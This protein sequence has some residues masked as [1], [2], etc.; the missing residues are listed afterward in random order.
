MPRS[1]KANTALARWRAS[2]D[3]LDAELVSL[4]ARRTRLSVQVARWKHRRG[5]PLVTPAREQVILARA[6]QAARRPLTPAAATRIFR[7]ILVEMRAVQSA[8]VAAARATPRRRGYAA[9]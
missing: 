9:Q 1:E 2:I 4:L 3:H 7:A 8:E 5:V 6:K